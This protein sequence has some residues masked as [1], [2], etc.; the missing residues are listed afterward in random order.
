MN[1]LKLYDTKITTSTRSTIFSDG[2]IVRADDLETAMQYPI[3]LFQ[4]LIR[5]Y[6]GCGVVCGLEVHMLP[7]DSDKPTF[8]L[9]LEPGVALDCGGHPL[10]ICEPVKIDLTPDPCACE[11][12]PQCLYLAIRRDSA[13][14]S[15]SREADPTSEDPKPRFEF[16]RRRELVHVKV[17]KKL[18]QSL[19]ARPKPEP[20]Q[21]AQNRLDTDECACLK[22]C[23]GCDCADADWVLLARIE[24]DECGVTRIDRSRRKYVKPIECRCG[25]D[26]DD[27][28]DGS[29]R[30]EGGETGAGGEVIP[31]LARARRARGRSNPPEPQGP[32]RAPVPGQ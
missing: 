18:P 31:S 7:R 17:F 11:D 5:A 25:V 19:C 23:A 3:A 6:F 32:G 9:Q 22:G 28:E 14:E 8:W 27:A 2:M 12:Q 21:E 15:P 24:L 13:S 26:P 4:T 16:R 30:D 10:S 1:E 20:P 29:P